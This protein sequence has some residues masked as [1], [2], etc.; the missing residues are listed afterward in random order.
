MIEKSN[1]NQFGIDQINS[2]LHREANLRLH[3]IIVESAASLRKKSPYKFFWNSVF[4][5]F[6]CSE[7]IEVVICQR[8]NQDEKLP[9]QVFCLPDSPDIARRHEQSHP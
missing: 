8:Q 9:A 5:N 6:L 1:L 7:F 2:L 3:N 4:L